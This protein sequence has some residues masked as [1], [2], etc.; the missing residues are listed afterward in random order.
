LKKT[1]WGEQ[2][3]VFVPRLD[4]E[5]HRLLAQ[6][7]QFAGAVAEGAT[8]AELEVR[9]KNLIDSF[10]QHCE[11]E[12]EA[13]R[14]AGY[15]QAAEH[16]EEHRRLI[17]QIKGLRDDLSAGSV[18]VCNALAVFVQVWTERHIAGPDA[19]LAVYLREGRGSG[20]AAAAASGTAS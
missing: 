15:P 7:N 2:L 20:A 5:H 17:A 13:M 18:Q 6:S 19:A 16:T 3:L 14:N 8:S 4:A 9:L 11:S 1:V 12:E 10:E